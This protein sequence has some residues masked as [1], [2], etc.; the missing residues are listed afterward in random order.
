MAVY[1]KRSFIVDAIQYDGTEKSIT[2]IRDLAIN[3][4]QVVLWPDKRLL[5]STRRGDLFIHPLDYV[6]R[7]SSGE[8]RPIKPEIFEENYILINQKSKLSKLNGK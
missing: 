5:L 2:G 8:I 3:G 7:N 1:R 4:E 6:V